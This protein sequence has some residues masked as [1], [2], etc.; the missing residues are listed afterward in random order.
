LQF[1]STIS[2]E[3][4]QKKRELRVTSPFVCGSSPICGALHISAYFFSFPFPEKLLALNLADALETGFYEAFE[5]LSVSGN[6]AHVFI[7]AMKVSLA[8]RV[9]EVVDTY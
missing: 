6:L 2:T 9:V 4:K 1:T 7:S 3:P 8:L 5:F